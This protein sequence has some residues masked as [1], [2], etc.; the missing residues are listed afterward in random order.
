MAQTGD[1]EFVDENGETILAKDFY[2]NRKSNKDKKIFSR[3]KIYTFTELSFYLN[4]NGNKSD[5]ENYYEAID[6]E[7]LQK[8]KRGK[9]L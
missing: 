9:C 8:I 7:T 2:R 6:Y 3:K 5:K 1:V 4:G